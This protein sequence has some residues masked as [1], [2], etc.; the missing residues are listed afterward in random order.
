MLLYG[1]WWDGGGG[2][3]QNHGEEVVDELG[4]W[5]QPFFVCFLFTH[6]I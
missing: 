2:G 4:G 3:V 6:T 1:A 5:Q